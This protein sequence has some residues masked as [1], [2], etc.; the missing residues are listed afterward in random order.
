MNFIHTLDIKD[1]FGTGKSGSIYPSNQMIPLTV[2]PLSDAHCM[3]YVVKMMMAI[4]RGICVF[5]TQQF[6]QFHEYV[7]AFDLG[8]KLFIKFHHTFFKSYNTTCDS[9]SNYKNS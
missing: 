2:I 7:D 1:L 3:P 4:K 6:F 5:G 8:T 9:L